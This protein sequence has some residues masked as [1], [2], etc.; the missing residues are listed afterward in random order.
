MPSSIVNRAIPIAKHTHCMQM[1]WGT[2]IH[3]LPAANAL[4][5]SKNHPLRS[6]MQHLQCDDSVCQQKIAY[7]VYYYKP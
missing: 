4:R 5:E 1:L 7:T 3:T 6:T 2:P